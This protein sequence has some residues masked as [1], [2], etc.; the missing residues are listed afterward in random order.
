[1]LVSDVNIDD[2]IFGA[3]IYQL[4]YKVIGFTIF[5]LQRVANIGLVLLPSIVLSP[6]LPM[7]T[8]LL[9]MS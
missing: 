3:M 9:T 1:M 8:I 2:A 4:I 7:G 6:H 5:T